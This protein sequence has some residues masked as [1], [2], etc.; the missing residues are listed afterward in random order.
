MTDSSRTPFISR[1][2]ARRSGR[3]AVMAAALLITAGCGTSPASS[4]PSTPAAP[5][6]TPAANASAAPAGADISRGVNEMLQQVQAFQS[7][8]QQGGGGS[9]KAAA[10]QLNETWASFEDAVRPR[11]PVQYADVEKFLSPLTAGAN[12]SVPDAKTLGQLAQQ[13]ADALQ[14]LGQAAKDGGGQTSGNAALDQAADRYHDWTVEQVQALQRATKRFTDAVR[15]GDVAKAKALYPQA[16]VYYERIEPIAETFGDLDPDIDAREGDVD[17][18]QWR[19]FHRI[20][21]ALWQTGSTEGL[22][23]VANRLDADVAQLASQIQARTIQPGEVVAGAVELL[24][25]AATTKITGEEE[26]YSHLDLVDLAANIEGSKQAYEA[27]EPIVRAQDA[28]LDATVQSRFRALDEA[29][30][31]YRSGDGF[32][33]YTKL[34][35]ADTR[36]ISRAIQAAAEP[37]AQAAKILG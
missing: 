27:I 2:H 9:L 21:K 15:Q 33:T 12:A 32:V 5:N 29:L 16:R 35:D 26:R 25:E 23:D 8:L 4:G 20:E 22:T 30:A 1:T 34:K 28:G 7:A 18:T 3:F 37:L 10:K 36:A 31:P 11:F 14:R 24:N 6:S 19:G 13:L 17:P